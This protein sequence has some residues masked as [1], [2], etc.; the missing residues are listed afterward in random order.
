MFGNDALDGFEYKGYV[1]SYFL[2]IEPEENCKTEHRATKDGVEIM[3]DWSPYSNPS[4]EEFIR[5]IDLGCPP[6]LDGGPLDARDL[7]LYEEAVVSLTNSLV[8]P[9]GPWDYYWDSRDFTR[10]EITVMQCKRKSQVET[11]G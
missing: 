1:Y 3:M 5:W 2:D 4:K 11:V 8:S 9:F 10:A 6:R 7:S